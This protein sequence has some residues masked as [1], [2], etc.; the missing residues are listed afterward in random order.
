ML[1]SLDLNDR[2]SGRIATYLPRFTAAAPPDPGIANWRAWEAL[3]ADRG[4]GAAGEDERGM[5]IVTNGGFG[6]LSSSLIALPSADH[7]GLR[8]V[9]R[10]C[11]GR[12]GEAPFEDVAL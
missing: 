3:L 2:A 10:F 11:A 1:T 12:P 6:T 9:W 4:S 7:A 5:V 8:P